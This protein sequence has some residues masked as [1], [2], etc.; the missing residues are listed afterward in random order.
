MYFGQS[1]AATAAEHG[2]L[3]VLRL[4]LAIYPGAPME[5]LEERDASRPFGSLLAL[6]AA[7]GHLDVVNFLLKPPQRPALAAAAAVADARAG[8]DEVHIGLADAPPAPP[9][10]AALIMAA[11]L[12]VRRRHLPVLQRLL[13]AAADIDKNV[14]SQVCTAGITT[15]TEHGYVR[16][17]GCLLAHG[18]E[19]TPDATVAL[20]VRAAGGGQRGMLPWLVDRHLETARRFSTAGRAA[21]LLAGLGSVTGGARVAPELAAFR[22]ALHHRG[23]SLMRAAA[24]HAADARTLRWLMRDPCALSVNMG[25]GS[26]NGTALHAAANVGNVEAARWLVV[27]AAAEVES[28]DDRGRTPLHVACTRADPH[29]IQLLLALGARLKTG[30]RRSIPAI[31][32]AQLRSDEDTAAFIHSVRAVAS[33]SNEE[34]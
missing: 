31:A 7:S 23:D 21:Q 20:M 33:H 27:R 24:R 2:R 25:A 4:L 9:S 15:A 17:A 22:G 3:A 34:L 8:H 13:S 10:A 12:A 18:F 11:Q 6:A 19:L 26:R 30:D 28:R 32:L 29:M 14:H 1:A 16:E 5:A